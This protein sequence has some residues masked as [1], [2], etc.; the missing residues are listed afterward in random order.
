MRG[1]IRTAL[2]KRG[3]WTEWAVDQDQLLSFIQELSP[4]RTSLPLRRFGPAA[5]GGYVAPDDL[6]GIG[7]CISPGVSTECGFDK[8]IGDL[9]VD[10]HLSDAT[11]SG[12]PISHPR[13][14]FTRKH[15]DTFESPGTITIDGFCKAIS[16]G[17]DLIL[18]MDIEGAEYRVL[19]SASTEL[20]SRFRIMI[21]EFHWLAHLFSDFGFHE[22]SAVFRRLLRTHNI[23]HIHPN[24]LAHV[25]SS[26]AI[27]IP[28]VMEFTLLRKDRGEFEYGALPYPSDLDAKNVADRPDIVLPQ[29]WRR[30]S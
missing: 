13:F 1:L 6:E 22:I 21:I 12:P 28:N 26:G 11:V 9:G 17:R 2:L 30:S 24:N 25:H 23:V 15:F 10:V 20:L 16:L 7:G 19:N 3:V 27:V 14:H 29:C 8:E 5:D 18:Q 4:M